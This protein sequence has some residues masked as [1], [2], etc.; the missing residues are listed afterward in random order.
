LFHAKNNSLVEDLGFD[1]VQVGN[2]APFRQAKLACETALKL[3][4]S[5]NS[6][7]SKEI[8]A[9]QNA[10]IEVGFSRCINQVMP[11]LLICFWN[12]G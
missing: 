12:H 6:T 8:C 1:Y 11:M 3:F 2:W 4:Q 7:S 5:T 9:Y 10:T